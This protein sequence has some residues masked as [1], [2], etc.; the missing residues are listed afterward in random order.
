MIE[1]EANQPMPE[2]RKCPECGTPLPAGALAGL[3]PA[4]LLKQGAAN[5]TAQPDAPAFEPPSV[6]EIAKLFPQLDILKLL[7]KGGMGAVYQARQPSLDRMVALKI[8]PAHDGTDPGFAE[9]FNREARALAR[10][11]HPNIVAVHEFGRAGD[12]HYFIMEFVDG[13]NL[14]QLQLAGRLSPREALQI[15]PQLCDALQYAHDQ[16]VVHRD[17]KPENVLMDRKGRVKIADFG[18]AK[19]LDADPAKMRLTAE[20]I[21]MGTP[22][23]MSPEQVEH[24]LDVDHRADIYSLGVVF[25]EMLT[26][27]LPLGRFAPP[28]SKV[29][30]DVRLDDVVLRT[31]EKE[32]SRRYQHA[33]QVKT[34]VET[35]GSTP[36]PPNS[37]TNQAL[38]AEILARDYVLS[39]G[40]CFRRGWALVRGDFWP[41]VGLTALDLTLFAT[42]NSNHLTAIFWMV[43]HGPLVGG[44][45]LYYLNKIRGQPASV[46]TAFS[47]FSQCFLHLFLGTFVTFTLTM[48]GFVCF[49]LPGLYLAVA[50]LFTLALIMDKR[51]HFWAAMELS[52]KMVSKHW[53]KFLG[54]ALILLAF[55]FIGMLLLGIGFFLTAPISVA[56]V[57][58]AYEDL[59]GATAASASRPASM[60]GAAP[61]SFGPSGTTVS[62]EG[63]GAVAPARS[64]CLKPVLIGLGVIGVIIAVIAIIVGLHT[65]FNWRERR[66]YSRAQDAAVMNYWSPPENAD[67]KPDPSKIL[68]EA[69]KLTESGEYEDALQHFLWYWNHALEYDSGQTGVRLSFALADWVELGR[70]YPKARTALVAIRDHDTREFNEGRGY[71]ALFSEVA[72][73]NH[74]LQSESDTLDI[75]RD[76]RGNDTELANQC[77][78]LVEGQLVG[79]RD[80]ATCM[81]YIPDPQAAFEDIVKSWQR[82]RQMETQQAD[83]H[84]QTQKAIEENNERMRRQHPEARLPKPYA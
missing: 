52:R 55:N 63:P 1:S 30:I 43:L 22:H 51:L 65:F 58:Y 60:P 16:G 4:C 8:L 39:I 78:P 11:S 24:P 56:A 49:I 48:F 79:N 62:P 83:M 18:L 75:F 29:Q 68:E 38:T 28:S 12:L 26:G 15:V 71:F 10:L 53:W 74:Y 27:E 21:V 67:V 40:S 72:A 32:P 13:V 3:C 76:F 25:Y 59:F 44:L 61:V 82:S 34:A 14:R 2:N 64:G 46:E 70:R 42:V 5:D 84:Q 47:G 69:K 80:Y 50:W 37:A 19:I 77:F 45:Y 6:P 57:M 36:T 17:I 33:S 54:F 9:R 35:I 7:G 73:L 66:N 81:E 31:L 20:G 41:L 23:Y